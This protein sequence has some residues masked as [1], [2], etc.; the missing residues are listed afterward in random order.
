MDLLQEKL[1]KKITHTNPHIG[2]GASSLHPSSVFM[3]FEWRKQQ[4]GAKTSF[5]EKTDETASHP[6]PSECQG[7]EE[8]KGT[9]S[10]CPLNQVWRADGI[11]YMKPL[12]E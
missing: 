1:L 5:K 9:F 6:N 12:E 4:E 11:A 3:R 7:L 2:C 10:R 8:L